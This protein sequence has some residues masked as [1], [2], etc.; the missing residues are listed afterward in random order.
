MHLFS[1]YS[2]VRISIYQF[3][4]YPFTYFL[5]IIYLPRTYSTSTREMTPCRTFVKGWVPT[6]TPDN[7]PRRTPAPIPRQRESLLDDFFSAAEH[8]Q[9]KLFVDK[10]A[11]L[12]SPILLHFLKDVL[13]LISPQVQL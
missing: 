12:L 1:L 10:C 2:S 4:V 3:Q 9:H 7:P 6:T 5:F 11:P 13:P 8:S